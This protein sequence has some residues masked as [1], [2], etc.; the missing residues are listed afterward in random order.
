MKMPEIDLNNAGLTSEE[1]AI[2]K[3]ILARPKDGKGTVKKSY[4]TRA[5]ATIDE[6]THEYSYPTE[7]LRI[8]HAGY[9]VWRWVVFQCCSYAPYVCIPSTTDFYVTGKN[10]EDRRNNHKALMDIAD[11]VVNT[12]PITQQRGILRWGNALGFVG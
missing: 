3:N 2:C 12:L 4:P 9:V 10:F 7:E 1:F 11:K 8:Y 6:V 5:Y